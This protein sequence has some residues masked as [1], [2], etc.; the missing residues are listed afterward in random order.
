MTATCSA[1]HGNRDKDITPTKW[2]LNFY[3][4]ES[5]HCDPGGREIVVKNMGKLRLSDCCNSCDENEI[6]KFIAEHTTLS[7]SGVRANLDW[8]AKLTMYAHVEIECDL[9][10]TEIVHVK[11]PRDRGDASECTCGMPEGQLEGL[12]QA[13][14]D[15]E[16]RHEKGDESNGRPQE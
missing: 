14:K 11:R 4:I 2:L 15:F 10:E 3:G 9:K 6:V 1:C 13:C 5:E 7:E 8:V 12:C 16:K